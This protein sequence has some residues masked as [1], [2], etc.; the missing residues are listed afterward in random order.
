MIFS[1]EDIEVVIRLQ[2]LMSWLQ[3]EEAIVGVSKELR[4]QCFLLWGWSMYLS[5]WWQQKFSVVTGFVVNMVWTRLRSKVIPT[6]T[7]PQ[8]C[9]YSL[10]ILQLFQVRLAV[11]CLFLSFLCWSCIVW[12]NMLLRQGIINWIE[13]SNDMCIGGHLFKHYQ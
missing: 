8:L 1:I 13:Y 4:S 3:V 2:F 10:L 7:P 9:H 11:R 5:G 12:S 6:T